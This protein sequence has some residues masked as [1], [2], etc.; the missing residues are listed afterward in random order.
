MYFYAVL[1][2]R[3]YKRE[4]TCSVSS[5]A[6]AREDLLRVP[7]ASLPPHI[8][9]PLL[10]QETSWKGNR[11][12]CETWA[13]RTVSRI[14]PND[15]TIS[16]IE[17]IEVQLQKIYWI[18]SKNEDIN[19]P[20]ASSA[21]L[22]CLPDRA[23]GPNRGKDVARGASM[24]FSL[25]SHSCHVYQLLFRMETPSP[26]LTIWRIKPLSKTSIYEV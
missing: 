4:V 16:Q 12:H 18:N 3:S 13:E 25:P 19:A 6:S 2:L 7:G 23:E 11:G 22:G 8:A 1:A 10:P 5:F 20:P 24:L 26:R 15:C 9:L 14:Q 17:T 21:G